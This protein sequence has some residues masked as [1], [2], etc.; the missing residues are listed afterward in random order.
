[1]S[2]RARMQ[3]VVARAKMEKTVIVE[4]PRKVSH[5]VYKKEIM[6]T[7]KIYAHTE[8]PIE[9]GTQVVVEE[10]KPI[11]KLKRWRVVDVLN[12]EEKEG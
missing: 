11:S 12:N 8:E 5:P 1:M 4:I 9:E 2:K 6:R 10:T 3:G 7:T